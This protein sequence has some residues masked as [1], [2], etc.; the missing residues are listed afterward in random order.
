M[1]QRVGAK[2][3]GHDDDKSSEEEPHDS[4]EC[5]EEDMPHGDI[6]E[7]P[8]DKEESSED[9]K[10]PRAKRHRSSHPEEEVVTPAESEPVE[11]VVA[12]SGR[13][14]RARGERLKSCTKKCGACI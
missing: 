1:A 14:E 10:T 13:G 11:E 9:N 7:S 8:D 12:P 4:R 3:R 5:D 6:D 2:E